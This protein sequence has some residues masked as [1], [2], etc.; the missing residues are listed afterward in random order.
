MT[1]PKIQ[2]IVI[3]FICSLRRIAA[4]IAQKIGTILI[5]IV[6]LDNGRNLRAKK[7]ATFTV[8]PRNPLNSIREVTFFG[9]EKI[10][11][12]TPAV[13]AWKELVHILSPPINKITS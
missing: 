5:I 1:A 11:M 7:Q 6:H 8:T 4:S 2:I 9:Y 3:K 10:L 13:I 12:L